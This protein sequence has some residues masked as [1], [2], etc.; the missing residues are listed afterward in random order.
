MFGFGQQEKN[1]SLYIAIAGGDTAEVAKL[2]KSGADLYGMK[3]KDSDYDEEWYQDVDF[4]YALQNIEDESLVIP[5]L[6]VLLDSG[7]LA[8]K[9]IQNLLRS[10]CE[11]YYRYGSA[12][13]AN[14]PELIPMLIK[15]YGI[16]PFAASEDNLSPFDTALQAGQWEKASIIIREAGF[17]CDVFKSLIQCYG[18]D[19]EPSPLLV[20]Q[21][22]G[23]SGL[24]NVTPEQ[25]RVLLDKEM[26]SRKKESF[27]FLMAEMVSKEKPFFADDIAL[28]GLAI[29]SKYTDVALN[30]MDARMPVNASVLRDA[31]CYSDKDVNKV[32]KKIIYR[33]RES[34]VLADMKL[35][36][37][38]E[39]AITRNQPLLVLSDLVE[40]DADVN[41]R[42]ENGKTLLMIA[43]DY[44][45]VQAVEYLRSMGARAEDVDN[46]GMMAHHYASL[47]RRRAEE[48]D[49]HGHWNQEVAAKFEKIRSDLGGPVR[50]T[51][52]KK[53]ACQQLVNGF[54]KISQNS[55]SMIEGDGL[56]MTFD[57]AARHVVY[58]DASAPAAPVMVRNFNEV[59]GVE[60]IRRAFNALVALGGTPPAFDLDIRKLRV[61][62]LDKKALGGAA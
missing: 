30:L 7:K 52:Q 4:M 16:D 15:D 2:L 57:F 50:E 34:G 45:N 36:E 54:K 55:V 3:S 48:K 23:D 10:V 26:N 11:D 53:A 17:K 8:S 32:I 6:R 62:R 44:G 12:S 43:A 39:I 40:A 47:G 51:E 46:D 29:R 9:D 14:H 21:I 58:R 41:A 28:L 56:T 61:V 42:F 37:A 22:V 25:R 19:R 5:M 60:A 33:A 38:L 20:E 27:D 59:Q 35:D 18:Y 49:D 1:N 24:S 13:M 31:V